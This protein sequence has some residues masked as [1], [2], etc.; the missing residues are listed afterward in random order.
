MKSIFI[1]IVAILAVTGLIL[2]AQ[3]PKSVVQADKTVPNSVGAPKPVV[4]LTAGTWKYK[5]T[6]VQPD[7][8]Y[9][10]TYSIT[11]KDGGVWTFTDTFETSDGPVTDVLTLEKGTLILRKELFKH[12]AKPG[13]PWSITTN[14]D[15]TTSK[16]TGTTNISGQDKP[17]AIDL[18]RPLFAGGPGSDVTIGC[19]PLVDGYST[20]F[21]N[22]DIQ[23]QEET[24][25]HL[26]VMGM[27]RVTVPAGTFDS[28][29]VDVTSAN[30]RHSYKGSV[31]IAKDSRTPVK[32]SG[33]E[34]VRRGPLV[35]VTSELVP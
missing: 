25:V 26:K 5:T 20:T 12:F 3:D 7:G 21:R 15:F 4:D 34:T 35:T 14:L 17:V 9:H 2:F 8:A 28:Y 29:K 31:W 30:G 16:V 11:I 32:V 33:S 27:E 19:L 18:S 13:R 10:D 1:K 24:L 23:S 6:V 22:F